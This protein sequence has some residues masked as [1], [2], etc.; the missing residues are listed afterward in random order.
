MRGRRRPPRRGQQPGGVG[1]RG[2]PERG[3]GGGGGRL[4]GE[5]RGVPGR[6]HAHGCGEGLEQEGGGGG[7]AE[8]EEGEFCCCGHWEGMVSSGFLF[9]LAVLGG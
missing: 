2:E 4:R 6:L 5:V 9:F 1:G 7:V 8:V 3:A